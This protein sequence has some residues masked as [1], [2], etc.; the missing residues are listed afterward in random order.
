MFV[1]V[2]QAP[3]MYIIYVT[4]V[5]TNRQQQTCMRC[6]YSRIYFFVRF[7]LPR[8]YTDMSVPCAQFPFICC[9]LKGMLFHYKHTRRVCVFVHKCC[10][11]CAPPHHR[12][13]MYMTMFIRYIAIAPVV[14]FRKCSLSLLIG[15]NVQL[16]VFD[17]FLI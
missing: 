14:V 1:W 3:F 9:L 2:C 11:C 5:Y 6:V 4:C 16:H 10:C 8:G 7:C 17:Q 13:T 12:A 15:K